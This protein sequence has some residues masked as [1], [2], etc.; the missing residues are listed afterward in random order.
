MAR[1]AQKILDDALLLPPTEREALAIQLFD[2]LPA[3][4]GIDLHAHLS[5][6][7]LSAEIARRVAELK[8]GAVKGIPWEHVRAQ[9]LEL[10]DR[11]SD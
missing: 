6:E 2:S 9:M 8:S 7:E 1:Q 3:E 10:S 11:D 4:E 5:D